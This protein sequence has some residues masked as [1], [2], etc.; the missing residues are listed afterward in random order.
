MRNLPFVPIVGAGL[1][2][3]ALV[4]HVWMFDTIDTHASADV[5]AA[6][7]AFAPPAPLAMSGCSAGMSACE[8]PMPADPLE[9]M[10]VF[11]L[12]AFVLFLG[13]TRRHLRAA[14]TGT[15]PSMDR[16]PP[17]RPPGVSSVVLLV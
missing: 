3:L 5:P 14:P 8:V 16:A 6:T 2:A 4:A 9:T 10:L 7:T 11:G 1:V 12:L 17:Q 13:V 15:A